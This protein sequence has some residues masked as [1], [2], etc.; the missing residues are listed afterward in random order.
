MGDQL[1]CDVTVTDGY[2]GQDQSSLSWTIDNSNPTIDAITM[3]PQEPFIDSEL[4]CEVVANDIDE[5]IS[6]LNYTSF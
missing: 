5:D 6:N 2:G 4:L 1:L 3:T